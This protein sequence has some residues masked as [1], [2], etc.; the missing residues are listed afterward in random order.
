MPLQLGLSGHQEN[1]RIVVTP[2]GM[3][4]E[5]VSPPLLEIYQSCL[6]DQ[7]A[8]S[9]KKPMPRKWTCTD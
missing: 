1:R 5:S 7:L 9:I 8:R 4:T 6:R 3:T 2:R